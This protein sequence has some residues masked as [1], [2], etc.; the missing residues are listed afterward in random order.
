MP[1][2]GHGPFLAQVVITRRCNIDC[3]YCN[4]YDKT[5]E[6][7]P[8]PTIRQWVDRLRWLRTYALEYTGGETLLHP[9]VVDLVGY[10]SSR[11][12]RER[13]IITNGFLLSPDLVDALG[14]AGLTHMQLSLDGVE[15]NE[16]TLKVLKTVRKKMEI[17]AERARFVVQV[18][19]VFGATRPSEAVEVARY[20]R[21]MG[22]RPRV[23][24]LHDGHG[25]MMLSAEGQEALRE[26]QAIVGR[27]WKESKDYRT[28]LVAEGS[29]DFKCR[30]GGR[31]LY[32]DE[33]GLVN[34]CSQQRG[35][36]TKPLLE[37]DWDDVRRQWDTKK[38]CAPT[39]TVGCVRTA[40]R[41]DEWRGQSLS[42]DPHGRW[43]ADN[44]HDLLPAS[45]LLRAGLPVPKRSQA[46][47]RHKD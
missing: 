5:S 21:D 20:A 34:W 24:I 25:S 29:A 41:F 27:R 17:L 30:A 8:A 39:C 44:E 35:V 36:F 18:N 13:W 23:S 11:G 46:A 37:Y 12:F 40:S 22:F 33:F 4:E 14:A 32:V 31:Y 7:V 19:A 38:G 42:A 43:P 6:P 9:D 16:T 47:L 1:W 45:R 26:A 15:P 2:L 28:R 3:G 10:A